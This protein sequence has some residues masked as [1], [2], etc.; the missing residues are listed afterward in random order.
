MA[1]HSSAVNNWSNLNQVFWLYPPL[2]FIWYWLNFDNKDATDKKYDVHAY[3]PTTDLFCGSKSFSDI[4]V[5]FRWWLFRWW[6]NFRLESNNVHETIWQSVSVSM[7]HYIR[8]NLAHG[9]AS[10]IENCTSS[11]TRQMRNTQ[12][13]YSIS[14]SHLTSIGIPIVQIRS[15]DHLFSTMGFPTLVIKRTFYIKSG[16]RLLYCG[17]NWI[18]K[19]TTGFAN[20]QNTN[21]W[22]MTLF[23]TNCI[24]DLANQIK[25]ENGVMEIN[26]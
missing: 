20:P 25:S 26:L 19:H 3:S 24:S 22:R 11:I 1:L 6:L 12:G 8:A 4:R 23:T 9:N 10:A 21:Q 7:H 14:K 5:Q 18:C 13:A 16:T 15:Y 17:F 2:K